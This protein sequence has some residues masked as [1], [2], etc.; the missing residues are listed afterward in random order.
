MKMIGEIDSIFGLVRMRLADSSSACEDFHFYRREG[1][2]QELNRGRQRISKNKKKTI[3][4]E[5][6]IGDNL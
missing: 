1:P 6:Q 5:N 4:S 2:N 3:N